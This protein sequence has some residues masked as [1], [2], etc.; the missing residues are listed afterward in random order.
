MRRYSVP[1]FLLL[2]AS[3]FLIVLTGCSG[4]STARK[5]VPIS[6]KAAGRMELP[7][8]VDKCLLD[9]VT[10]TWYLQQQDSPNIYFYRNGGQIN[11]AGGLGSDNSNFQKLSDIAIDNDGYLLALDGFARLVKKFSPDGKWIAD[12]N[13]PDFRQPENFCCTPENN[14]IIYD[15]ATKELKSV[16]GLDGRTLFTFSRFQVNTVSV[17]TANSEVIAVASAIDPLTVLFSTI[18]FYKMD[19]PDRLVVDQYLNRYFYKDGT[20][21]LV[22]QDLVLPL[23]WDERETGLYASPGALLL[24]KGNIVVTVRPEYFNQ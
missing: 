20:L 7:F 16:S 2:A 19:Y 10:G 11:S 18:G 22:G 23:G 12:I 5:I 13:L 8:S 14:L 24:V 17:I 15:A 6:L 1:G 9:Q 21:H 3:I 4:I